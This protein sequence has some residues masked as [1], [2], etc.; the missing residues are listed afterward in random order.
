[1]VPS[2]RCSG[3]MDRPLGTCPSFVMNLFGAWLG[4]IERCFDGTL[5]F[6]DKNVLV[7]SSVSTMLK[8]RESFF[9]GI[10]YDGLSYD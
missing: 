7:L 8:T 2:R 1:M 5:W 3:S 4:C 9:S 10:I 6:H